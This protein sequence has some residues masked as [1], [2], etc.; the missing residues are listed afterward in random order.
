MGQI[1]NDMINGKCC[2]ICSTFFKEE[3]GYPVACK[4]CYNELDEE[5]KEEYQ[6]ASNEQIN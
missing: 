2:S 1:A 3:H 4:D 6:L 5:E